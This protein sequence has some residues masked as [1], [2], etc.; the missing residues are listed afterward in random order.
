M[1]EDFLSRWSRLKRQ[2]GA[3]ES[4]RPVEP[5]AP[6]PSPPQ[7]V[8]AEGRTEKPPPA[9]E[10]VSIDLS[11]LPPI[12]AIDA[13]T[14]IRPFLRPGVPA[15][16]TRAALRRAWS[17][18]PAIRDF[19]GLAENAWDFNAPASVPGFGPALSPEDARRLLAEAFKEGPA[20]G[21]LAGTPN[22]PEVEPGGGAPQADAGSGGPQKLSSVGDAATH[23]EATEDDAE[24]AAARPVPP[25]VTARRRHGGALPQ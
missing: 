12:E 1:S 11:A 24:R 22:P 5:D 25:A 16:L 20:E 2:G 23:K 6:A 17:A 18:D 21:S 13:G 3:H 4:D 8:S 10:P 7:T 15:E 14:D 19:V 9:P